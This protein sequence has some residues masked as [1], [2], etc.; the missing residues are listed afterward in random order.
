MN[1]S[2]LVFFGYFLLVNSLPS[3]STADLNIE[4]GNCSNTNPENMVHNAHVH[5]QAIPFIVR[6]VSDEWYGDETIYCVRAISL[7][8]KT[9]G[10]TAWITDG[11]VNH[12]YVSIEMQS[13]R[14]KGLEYNITVFAV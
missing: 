11:G 13:G 2:I 4:S 1:S 12:S 9:E 8:D 3:N 10:S 14:G 6:D 7:K 5:K